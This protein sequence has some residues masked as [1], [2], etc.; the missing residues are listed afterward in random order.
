MII[1]IFVHA[2]ILGAYNYDDEYIKIEM[3]SF[4]RNICDI[5]IFNKNNYRSANNNKKLKYSYIT[6]YLKHMVNYT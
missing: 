4:K 2:F 6:E 3:N 5:S 1:L